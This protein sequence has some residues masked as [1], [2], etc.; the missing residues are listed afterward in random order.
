LSRHP[1][2]PADFELRPLTIRNVD[3]GA[4]LRVHRVSR[5]PLFFGRIG[6]NRFDAPDKAFG[7]CYAG[8]NL[9]CCIVET[10]IRDRIQREGW[11]I[12][13]PR[14]ELSRWWVATIASTEPLR[15]AEFH[16]GSLL[17]LG[18]DGRLS[19]EQPY[20]AAQAWSAAVHAHPAQVHGFIYRSRFDNCRYAIALFERAQSILRA[21]DSGLMHEQAE[22]PA[23]F[24]SYRIQIDPMG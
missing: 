5:S 18:G 24:R 17:T 9:E 12:L 4:L 14:S 23:I 22:T 15:L 16:G 19:T 1:L 11:P 6:I 3:S 20:D 2:P 13:V 7:V 8:F 10:L 21:Q